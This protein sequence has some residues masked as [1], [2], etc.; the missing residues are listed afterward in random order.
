M[1][2]RV[3]AHRGE[4]AL[5][6][7]GTESILVPVRNHVGD[8][9]SVYVF[10]SVAARIWSLIDGERDVDSI[11]ATICSEYDADPNVVRADLEELLGSLEGAALIGAAIETKS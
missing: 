11:V 6:Q 9:D 1:D 4:F 7:V 2:N 8:L 5:R 10:T 3:F